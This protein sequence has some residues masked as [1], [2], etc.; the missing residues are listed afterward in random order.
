MGLM[1]RTSIL[2][3][4]R[5]HRP[6]RFVID[7]ATSFRQDRVRIWLADV[8]G[9]A[10]ASA[11][12]SPVSRSV[13]ETGRAG[14][15]LHRLFAGPTI[16][17]QADGL[18][19]VRSHANGFR[20]LRIGRSGIARVTLTGGCDAGGADLTVADEIMPTLRQFPSADWVKILDPDGETQRPYGPT[21]SIPDCLAP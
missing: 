4:A 19:L 2:R 16:A 12:V 9:T 14:S 21:D 15:A 6:N 3:T 20:D 11:L 7:V 13:P 10:G 8:G 18:R 5:L 17:E 1:K